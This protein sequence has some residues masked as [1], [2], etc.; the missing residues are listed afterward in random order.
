MASNSLVTVVPY[1]AQTATF[2]GTAVI[3]LPAGPPKRGRVIRLIVGIITGTTPTLAAKMQV[4]RD[5]GTTWLDQ[6]I[7]Q[8]IKSSTTNN[9]TTVGEYYVLLYDEASAVAGAPAPQFRF[10]GT[11][12][13][14]TPSF[15]MGVDVVVSQPG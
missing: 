14:T 7:F 4:S 1:G 2:N 6:V 12:G 13:G 5:G 8:N 11:I 15:T 10:V 3:S 9:I